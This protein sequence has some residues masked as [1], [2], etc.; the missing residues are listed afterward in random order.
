MNPPIVTF[1]RCPAKQK[2]QVLAVDGHIAECFG[3]V[4]GKFGNFP[5]EG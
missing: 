5:R 2:I 1:A 3:L 4:F